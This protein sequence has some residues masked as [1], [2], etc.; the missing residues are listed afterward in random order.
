MGE[1]EKAKLCDVIKSAILSYCIN[2]NSFQI[3]LK[4]DGLLGLTIDKKDIILISIKDTIEN[5]LNSSDNH[6]LSIDK[7]DTEIS[8]CPQSIVPSSRRKRKP[9]K[10]VKNFIQTSVSENEGTQHL[11]LT[12]EDFSKDENPHEEK[13]EV[14]PSG[15][16]NLAF[17]NS[18]TVQQMDYDPPIIN[19]QPPALPLV[20]PPPLTEPIL[21]NDS[22]PI[23]PL[24]AGIQDI[25]ANLRQLFD[26]KS[27]I[28][29]VWSIKQ[30]ISITT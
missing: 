30:F 25:A 8:K 27:T 16:D 23:H 11:E 13:I 5:D 7:N 26:R 3:E 9:S 12:K 28:G 4:I 20:L 17:F 22:L 24:R 14:K 10:V 21:W 15:I 18:P 2:R 1:I 29:E 6:S 19:A